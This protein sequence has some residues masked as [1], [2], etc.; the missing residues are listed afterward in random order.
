MWNLIYFQSITYFLYFSLCTL[1]LKKAHAFFAPCVF[2]NIAP[3]YISL[4]IMLL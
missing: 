3:I 1:F 2:D 4:F